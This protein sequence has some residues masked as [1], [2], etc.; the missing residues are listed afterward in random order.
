MQQKKPTLVGD[1]LKINIMKTT[2]L[3]ISRKKL[4]MNRVELGNLADIIRQNPDAKQVFELRLNY[5]L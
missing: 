4:V 3:K 1:K 2:I 5:H